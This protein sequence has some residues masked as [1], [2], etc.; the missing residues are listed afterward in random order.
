MM[1]A[2][3][4]AEKL[5]TRGYQVH[6]V[7]DARGQ[8]FIRNQ[9]LKVTV[10][11]VKREAGLKGKVSYVL[12]LLKS[13]WIVLSLFKKVKNTFAEREQNLALVSFGGYITFPAN[14]AAIL[15]RVPFMLHEQNAYMGLVNRLFA[16]CARHVA[17]SMPLGNK[18][19]F[20]KYVTM[21]LTGMPVR[22]SFY[23]SRKQSYGLL[24]EDA[25]GLLGSMGQPLKQG[26]INLLVIGGSQGASIFFQVVP[27]ALRALPQH[28][29]CRLKVS[30]QSRENAPDH[31]TCSKDSPED[32]DLE[33]AP[34]FPDMDERLKAADLVIARAGAST[35]A[36][37][38]VVGRPSL[39]V[40]YPYAA[41]N[42]QHYNA[43]ILTENYAGW[44]MSQENFSVT[45]L[46]DFLRRL[47][48]SPSALLFA[49]ERARSFGGA[50][51][52]DLLVAC[53]EKI[54]GLSKAYG[55]FLT[56]KEK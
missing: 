54:L 10:L 39:L 24:A 21:S 15:R 32:L 34:F 1:P 6:F 40:P 13:F 42:H 22:D 5:L 4:L 18:P 29:R 49:A 51:A 19:L 33:V 37:L 2:E 28:I 7:T 38:A 36:E 20:S 3:A 35:V 44:S 9:N 8:R 41:G 47:F 43:K 56:M 53:L 27:E 48:E 12:S 16:F 55:S 52:T 23:E 45:G 50:Q 14:L 46:A 25:S 30:L 11:P 31:E 26:A 17:L